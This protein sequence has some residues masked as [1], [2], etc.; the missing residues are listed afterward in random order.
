MKHY[1]AEYNAYGIYVS[2]ESF[3]GPGRNGYK[4]FCFDTRDAR[5]KWVL[6]NQYDRDGN[7]VADECT[8][9]IVERNL[10]KKFAVTVSGRCFDPRFICRW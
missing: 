10:G 6:N 5:D 7:I 2:Y 4:F 9:A 3:G 8:R 1:Y